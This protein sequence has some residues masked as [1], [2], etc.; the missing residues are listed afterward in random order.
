MSRILTTLCKVW[1]STGGVLC[2]SFQLVKLKLHR[3]KVRKVETW[4][5]TFISH[6][7]KNV[8]ITK[9]YEWGTKKVFKMWSKF[10]IL[11][12]FASSLSEWWW[13]AVLLSVRCV[14]KLWSPG[15]VGH[16]VTTSYDHSQWMMT[17]TLFSDVPQDLS[18]KF[19]TVSVQTD[20]DDSSS[21]M[22]KDLLSGFSER[23]VQLL[24]GVLTQILW[25]N[26]NQ[27]IPE[28]SHQLFAGIEKVNWIFQD[29]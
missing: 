23:Q 20:R 25:R 13:L 2:I 4:L 11:K 21:E 6:F 7:H 19:K 17:D 27:E 22:V 24:L 16:S 1:A 18:A 28:H 8:L 5:V 12:I 26:N 29:I 14:S 9:K 10:W 3:V 15:R